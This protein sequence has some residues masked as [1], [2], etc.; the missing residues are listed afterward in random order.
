MALPVYYWDFLPQLCYILFSFSHFFHNSEVIFFPSEISNSVTNSYL[1]LSCVDFDS[2]PCI[3]FAYLYFILYCVLISYKLTI[4]YFI[5]KR[6]MQ[7][8]LVCWYG[9]TSILLRFF[10]SALL[11]LQTTVWCSM[12]VI[13]RRVQ[14]WSNTCN[15]LMSVDA[16]SLLG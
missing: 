4:Q 12:N 6:S 16:A 7:F 14:R 15:S 8:R 11:L 9:T 1:I 5:I 10:T 13:T 2:F 3:P